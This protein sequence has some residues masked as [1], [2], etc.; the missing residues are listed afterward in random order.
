MPC[1]D[2][3]VTVVIALQILPSRENATTCPGGAE[4]Y[5]TSTGHGRVDC[6]G[7]KVTATPLPAIAGAVSPASRDT[8]VPTGTAPGC[9]VTVARPS[10]VTT[11]PATPA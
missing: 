9:Q 10:V 7:E 1:S 3:D 4:A 5:A 11:A 2:G 8:D 6:P